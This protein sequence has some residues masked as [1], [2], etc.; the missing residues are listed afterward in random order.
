MVLGK[1]GSE[2]NVTGSHLPPSFIESKALSSS[3]A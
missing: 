2:I 1:V 3:L